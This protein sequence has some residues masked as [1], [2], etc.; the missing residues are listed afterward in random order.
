M[1]VGGRRVAKNSRRRRSGSSIIT[2]EPL[3]PV[4]EYDDIP[5]PLENFE[6]IVA[7][8]QRFVAKEPVHVNA[9]YKAL[10]NSPTPDVKGYDK[11]IGRGFHSSPG[12]GGRNNQTMRRYHRVHQPGFDTQRRPIKN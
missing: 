12:Y 6:D 4:G 11:W 9:V 7:T 8:Y 2:N 5:V 1:I 3:D 10:D